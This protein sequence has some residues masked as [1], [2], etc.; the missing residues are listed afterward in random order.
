MQLSVA[1]GTLPH[2]VPYAT[3]VDESF[4]RGARPAS[5]TL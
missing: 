4:A 3:Y 2:P 5:I 1:A